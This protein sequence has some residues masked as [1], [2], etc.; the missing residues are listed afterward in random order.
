M[1]FRVVE[2]G[3][4]HALTAPGGLEEVGAEPGV[5]PDAHDLELRRR[6]GVH[7]HGAHEGRLH[8][9]AFIA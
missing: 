7:V 1:V 3:A 5:A 8:P 6:P 2:R 4:T 9:V